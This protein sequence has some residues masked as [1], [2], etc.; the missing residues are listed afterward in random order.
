M[1][2]RIWIIKNNSVVA[3]Y[4]DVEGEDA[5]KNGKYCGENL[6]DFWMTKEP[7]IEELKKRADEYL[8]SYNAITAYL[9]K[10]KPKKPPVAVG[11]KLIQP[12]IGKDCSLSL[13]NQAKFHFNLKGR[14]VNKV[15]GSLYLD[16]KYISYGGIIELWQK[17]TRL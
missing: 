10:L 15:N 13:I 8:S 5:Y 3:M 12:A 9:K 17:E 7:A 1:N 4:A 6:I 16:G 11:K 14:R 2:I